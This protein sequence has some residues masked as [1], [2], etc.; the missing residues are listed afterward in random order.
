MMKNLKNNFIEA[1]RMI[2]KCSTFLLSTHRNPDADAIGSEIALALALKK[3]GKETAII[4]YSGTPDNLKFLPYSSTI[5]VKRKIFN[6]SDI[7][8]LLDC[9]SPDRNGYVVKRSNILRPI[10]YIDHHITNKNDVSANLIEPSASST[11]EIIYYFLKHIGVEIDID[12][13]TCLYAGIFF[14]TGGLRYSNATESAY[15][16]CYHLVKMGVPVREIS[17]NLF[18][19]KSFSSQSLLAV[20][21][22]RI[23]MSKDEKVCWTYLTEKDYRK[24]DAGNNDTDGFIDRLNETTGVSVSI[25]F[26]EIDANLTKVSLRS[27]NAVDVSNIASR[28]GGGGH[29]SASGFLSKDCLKKT[30]KLVL[31]EI[32]EKS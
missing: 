11:S 8:V 3:I 28:F 4:N 27:S 19:S 1:N 18:E 29:K 16:I 24:N 13:A 23:Q 6:K 22:S 26:R 32:C 7:A 10:F 15:K 17:R 12:I 30:M 2:G 31:N 5:E 14:D 20:A 25:F 21:L 9:E